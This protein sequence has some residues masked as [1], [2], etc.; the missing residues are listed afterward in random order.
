M[1]EPRRRRARAVGANLGALAA[2]S[3]VAILA[4]L[5]VLVRIPLAA[6]AGTAGYL[7]GGWLSGLLVRVARR[8]RQAP[9]GRLVYDLRA[10]PDGTADAGGKASALATLSQ[11]GFRVPRGF[12]VLPA[13]FAGDDLSP[14]GRRD[15]ARTLA[16]LGGGRFAVRSSATGEDSATA[17]FAGAFASE[18]DLTADAVPAAVLRVH[19][20]AASERVRA[21]AEAQ[22][23]GGS[24]SVAVVVQR[25]VPAEHAGVL[26]TVDP[27]TGD[28]DQMVGDAV[29]GPGD[30]LV[31]GE[32]DAERFRLHRP[33]GAYSGPG[34]LAGVAGQL[35]AAAHDIEGFFGGVGEDIE[36]AVAGGRV[37]ILQARPITTL[38]GWNP[39]TAERNDTLTGTCLWS[40]TNLSEANPEPQTP[41]TVS[42]VRYQ[43]DHG[44]PSMKLR[45]REMA[46]YVGGRPYANLSVQVSARGPKAA[47]DPRAAYRRL[48]GL[49][50]ELPEGVP[51]PVLPMTRADWQEEGLPLLRT[52]FRLARH[53]AGL[54]RF[55]ATS[56]AACRQLVVRIESASTP[57]G[58]RELW[59]TS[60][61]PASLRSFWA[62]ISA[63]DDRLDPVEE[64]LRELVG[65]QDAAA[66]L[67]N[68]AGL[69]GG[70]AS[71]GPAAGLQEVLAGTLTREDYLAAFGHRGLNEVELAW[72]R[73]A[74]DPA[75]LDR[76]L[77][78]AAAGRA[79][80]GLRAARAE[81]FHAALGRLRVSRPD[82]ARSIERRLRRRARRAALRESV[83]S[84]SVRWTGVGRRFAL[85][86]GELLGLGDDVFLLTLPELLDELAG[87]S[88]ARVHLPER[89]ALLERQRA[90]PQLP[91][92]I[93]GRFDPYA[94]AADPLRRADAV[95]AA[96][97][98]PRQAASDERVITGAAG[99]LGVATGPVRRLD[100][101]EDADQLL[102][103]EV[104]VTP[105]TN[106]G[107]TP[108]FPRA[109]AI[110][111][112]LGAPLSHA[113][114]VARE[115]G[116]PAVVGCGNATARLAT[117]DR[118]RVDG[119]RGTVELL[120]A[121]QAGDTLEHVFDS[122]SGR[123]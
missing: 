113:A 58:L 51:L 28:L 2:G 114:I 10:L 86:A 99:S 62:V 87:C 13:A 75:W 102:P 77:D 103:G 115:L 91:L 6:V 79:V 64:E 39:V 95:V 47:A 94:W 80:A 25:M 17:S 22:G 59:E 21:Y 37:W 44:G 106:I 18:L 60:L 15:L 112:D 7:V 67:A 72:P 57:A 118:V 41:L 12:V 89:R 66:L 74:E 3:A 34:A 76:A 5:P 100:R 54:P 123:G 121:D 4:P 108:V 31:S 73:P 56:A 119:T 55:L 45:G 43:Q 116:I 26:F 49:W 109:A 23:V 83:R 84:E 105:L 82:R 120:D 90:L 52:L 104:L 69:S 61:F 9:G 24:P 81:E 40:A 38:N 33:D 117:G 93:V 85:R 27:L 30:A 111:T 50:G 29:D 53:R 96:G 42:L 1:S 110:V 71:L 14:A 48:A 36:W 70:L 122:R 68:I 98:V 92:F 11:A 78:A 16:R 63:T 107:W 97:E 19:G 35:H 101:L 46:G 88:D 32:A 8:L 65:V 20:S